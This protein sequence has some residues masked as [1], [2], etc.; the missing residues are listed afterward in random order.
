MTD[1]NVLRDWWKP[2]HVM[3]STNCMYHAGV[4]KSNV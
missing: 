4:A 1:D 2:G 3:C